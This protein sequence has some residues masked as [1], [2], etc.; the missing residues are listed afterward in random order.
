MESKGVTRNLL[1]RIV[2]HAARWQRARDG[3]ARVR[4]RRAGPGQRL[5]SRARRPRAGRSLPVHVGVGLRG[6]IAV[7]H[8][9]RAV[10][11]RR[12]AVLVD[13][14]RLALPAAHAGAAGPEGCLSNGAGRHRDSHGADA[15]RV[16]R[17]VCEG[18]DEFLPLKAEK[19]K[20][21]V[22]VVRWGLVEFRRADGRFAGCVRSSKAHVL[23]SGSDGRKKI[24]RVAQENR[25]ERKGIRERD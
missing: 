20:S 14:L 21:V 12:A 24:D 6:E 22:V 11:A 23:R 17:C 16:V 7:M 9:L 15:K 18:F 8:A 1:L 2:R 4:H 3:S 13:T 5:A 10:A 19:K 25:E